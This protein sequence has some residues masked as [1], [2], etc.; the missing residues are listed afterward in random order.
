MLPKLPWLVNYQRKHSETLY[1]IGQIIDSNTLYTLEP[2]LAMIICRN[3]DKNNICTS[4]TEFAAGELVS[5]E[6]LKLSCDLL[7]RVP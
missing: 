3:K 6:R 4:L 7:R 1:Q 5:I 2:H